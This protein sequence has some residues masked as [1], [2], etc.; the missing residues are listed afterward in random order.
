MT[1][2][3]YPSYMVPHVGL[4][5]EVNIDN[6]LMEGD[7]AVARRVDKPFDSKDFRR[8]SDGTWIVRLDS[9]L[10]DETFDRIPNLSMT[11]LRQAFPL[12]SAKY[13]LEMKP[14][15]DDWKGGGINPWRYR[16]KAVRMEGPF[17]MVYK[18]SSLHN[19]P[20]RYQRRFE[21]KKLAEL[22][23][24]HYL[25]LR[26]DLKNGIYTNNQYYPGI[27]RVFLKHAP[28]KLNFW[29]YEL[30]LVN[31]EGESINNVKQTGDQQNMKPTFVEF[32]WNHFLNKMFWI[33]EN[34]CED[35]PESCFYDPNVCG[36]ERW[37]AEIMTKILF[38]SVPIVKVRQE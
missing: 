18:A 34:P 29:H 25:G 15:V 4:S 23:K 35:V 30:K 32:V 38:S 11:M 2:Q 17:L 1:E 9:S 22:V 6:I 20:A 14:K 31:A 12:K 5:T 3:Y 21:G 36:I 19:K 24:E 33:D 10:H 16:G 26:E 28:T 7:L 37:V 8:M 13:N 27:G